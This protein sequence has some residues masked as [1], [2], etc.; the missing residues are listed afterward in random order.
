MEFLPIHDMD[1]GPVLTAG[2]DVW[3]NTPEPPVHASGTTGLKAARKDSFF[4]TRRMMQQY[5]LKA[6]LGQSRQTGH[7]GALPGRN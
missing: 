6:N 3:L 7:F 1:R 2:V 4:N 5:V